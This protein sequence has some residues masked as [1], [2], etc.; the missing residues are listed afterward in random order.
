MTG[1]HVAASTQ[2]KNPRSAVIRTVVVAVL[3]LFPS[4]N[5]ILAIIVEELTP[6]GG[7]LPAWVFGILNGG[8]A[9]TTV[10]LGIG[11]RILAIPG[12][13]DWLRQHAAWLAPEGR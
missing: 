13:N 5:G 2:E 3:V 10:L 6:Y 11:T 1:D 12:V 9:V 7:Q 8:I 4:V